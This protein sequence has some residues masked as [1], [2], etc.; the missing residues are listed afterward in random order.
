MPKLGASQRIV[1]RAVMALFAV[2]LPTA[3]AQSGQVQALAEDVALIALAVENLRDDVDAAQD[4]GLAAQLKSVRALVQ[5]LEVGLGQVVEND[6]AQT[7]SI[8]EL[9]QR[10]SIVE[11]RLDIK[12]AVASDDA[13]TSSKSAENDLQSASTATDAV[14]DV[15]PTFIE[16]PVVSASPDEVDERSDQVRPVFSTPPRLYPG[17]AVSIETSDEQGEIDR[18]IPARRPGADV[19][20]QP[21]SQEDFLSLF[22]A[23]AN[24]DG[25]P[26]DEGSASQISPTQ[27]YNAAY[28]FIEVN[29][30]AAAEV[31][32]QNFLDQYPDHDLASNAGYW[33]GESFYARDMYGA[34]VRAFAGSVRDNRD[35]RKAPD[36]LLKLSMT[37]AVLGQKSEACRLLDFLPQEYPDASD[38]VLSRADAERRRLVCTSPE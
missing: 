29:D 12:P 35:G 1:V 15:S 30:L 13:L 27:A 4:E 26:S 11:Q 38:D 25:S 22:G 7:R 21:M 3:S 5:S 17:P 37:L 8:N 24:V 16:T 19:D 6:R 2:G 20:P 34:A 9:M 14:S 31:A 36:A 23:D 33:L 28:A 32:F 18:P 10:L